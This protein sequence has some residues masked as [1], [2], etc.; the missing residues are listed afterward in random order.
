[1]WGSSVGG[2]NERNVA[3]AAERKPIRPRAL[4]V[5]EVKEVEEV[6]DSEAGPGWE[7][8]WEFVVMAEVV[9]G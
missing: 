6:E 5:N 8:D 1:M 7:V 2:I 9:V 4:E 3:K